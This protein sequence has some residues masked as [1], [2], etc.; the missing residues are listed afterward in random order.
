M[1]HG[2]FEPL[3][4]ISLSDKNSFRIGGRARYYCLP[5]RNQEIEMSIRWA[6]E[7]EIPVFVLGKGTNVLISD[8]GLNGLVLNLVSRTD[9]DDIVWSDRI[10]EVP[11]GAPLSSIVK[12]SAEH[13]F[14][15]M[16]ELAGIP[17]TVGGAIA[18]NAGAFSQCIADTLCS[19]ICFD[20][21][22][23]MVHNREASGLG[24]RYRSSMLMSSG[25]IVISARFGFSLTANPAGLAE[26]HRSVFERRKLRQPLE[27]PNCGSVFKRPSG[28]FAGTLIEQCGL[29]G[30]RCGKA[31]ISNKHANF[32]VNTGG[33]SAS[34]VRHLIGLIQRKVFERF[35]I[36]LEPEVIFM[37]EFEEP[38][39]NPPME[40][41]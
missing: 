40:K 30:L 3:S 20:R 26:I 18:M 9:R 31:E 34:D 11:G 39:Y 6:E 10:A 28:S 38:L 36:L 15:G 1:Y 21:H 23:G 32:I 19:V 27:Y 29:K 7:H 14:S 35:S 41:R 8:R 16:E 25:E 37:G 24:L 17:G 12:G 4:N 2:S 5:K 13:G 22:T 33:A